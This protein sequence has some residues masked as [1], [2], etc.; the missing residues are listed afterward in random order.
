MNALWG[1]HVQPVSYFISET[2]KRFSINFDIEDPH[3]TLSSEFYFRSYRPSVTLTLHEAK[4]KEHRFSQRKKNGYHRETAYMTTKVCSS[5][6]DLQ[7]LFEPFHNMMNYF[8]LW[9]RSVLGLHSSAS[10]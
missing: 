8:L 4:N 7:I 2:P 10:V 3:S 1:G 9:A 5:N 6:K